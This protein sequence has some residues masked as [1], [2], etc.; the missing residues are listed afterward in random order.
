MVFSFRSAP[1]WQRL[2]HDKAQ[3]TLSKIRPGWRLPKTTLEE[4]KRRS[5]ITGEFIQNLLTENDVAIT[6]LE[7]SELISKMAQKELSAESV[8]TAFCKRAAFAHQLV[9]QAWQRPLSD[10]FISRSLEAEQLSTRN[11]LRSSH[12]AGP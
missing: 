3:S 2:A 10:A 1:S 8:A 11:L 7:A 6:E 4:A 12:R 5:D 9:S